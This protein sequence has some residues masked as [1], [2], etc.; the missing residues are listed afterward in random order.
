[1]RKL[2]RNEVTQNGGTPEEDNTVGKI[3]FLTPDNKD[4]LIDKRKVKNNIPV[5]TTVV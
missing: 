1:M 5:T 3:L 2:I 4:N